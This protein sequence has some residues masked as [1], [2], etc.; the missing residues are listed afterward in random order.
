MQA[1]PERDRKIWWGSAWLNQ[2]IGEI[3]M[4]KHLT[5]DLTL[6]EYAKTQCV[7]KIIN[8]MEHRDEVDFAANLALGDFDILIWSRV[9]LSR[10]YWGKPPATRATKIPQPHFDDA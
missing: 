5:D 8:L 10:V 4:I 7:W 3:E 9:V 1:L 6:A 2:A